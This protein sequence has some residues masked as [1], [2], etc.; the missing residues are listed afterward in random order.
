MKVK[1]LMIAI[2][3]IIGLLITT[4]VQAIEN[5]E[6]FDKE[7]GVEHGKFIPHFIGADEYMFFCIQHG[8]SYN[9]SLSRAT[10]GS[11]KAGDSVSSWCTAESQAPSKP[12][13]GTLTTLIY[14]KGSKVEE[15][16]N[17][18]AAYVLAN[19]PNLATLEAQMSIWNTK[20]NS[21][22]KETN[23]L[24]L[25]AVNYR[26]F[27]ESIH[28]NGNDIFDSLVKDNTVTDK[29][30]KNAVKVAVNQ[31]DGYYTVGPFN[32]SYPNSQYGENELN[33]WSMIKNVTLVDQAG[34]EIGDVAAGKL[35]ILDSNGQKIW[36]SN[37]NKDSK[38]GEQKNFP[39]NG[40][41]FYIK[42]KISTD[43]TNVKLRV[44]FEYLES[45][46]A[47]L[48]EFDGHIRNWSWATIDDGTHMHKR[49]ED[50][51]IQGPNG[52]EN[53]P[54]EVDDPKPKKKYKLQVTDTTNATQK[55][56]ALVGN[57]T[58]NYKE[59]NIILAPKGIDITM[60]IS[61]NVFLDKPEGK[62]NVVNNR[63]GPGEGLSGIEVT[64]YDSHGNQVERATLVNNYHQHTGSSTLGT[65]CYTTAVPHEH[66][67]SQTIGGG[68]Y[69]KLKHTHDEKKCFK[70]LKHKHEGDPQKG[71]I[72]YTEPIYHT[73][74][75]DSKDGGICYK[76]VTHHHEGDNTKEGGCYTGVV[77]A[78]TDLCYDTDKKVICGKV[79]G[80][81]YYELTCNKGEGQTFF[82]LDCD[83]EGMVERYD[84]GCGE[85]EDSTE[86]WIL[87][88]K[89]TVLYELDCDKGGKAD[90]YEPNC[91]K[92]TSHIEGNSTKVLQNPTLTKSEGYYEFA[93]LDAQKTYYVRFVYNGMLY[94][95]VIPWG[96]KGEDNNAIDVS[97]ATE[98]AQGHGENRTNFNVKFTEIGSYPSNYKIIN[99]IFGNDLGDYNRTYLQEEIAD[100]FKEVANKVVELDG[101][102]NEA[103]KAVAGSDTER[104]RKVQFIADCRINAYTIKQYP[105]T[106]EFL[107]DDTKTNVAGK[108]YEPIYQAGGKYD[109]THVNLGIKAR[110]TFDMAL[111]KDVFKAVLDINGKSETYTYDE[112]TDTEHKGFMIGID[113]EAYLTKLR[114]KYLDSSNTI[115]AENT[116]AQA[117]MQYVQQLRA[118]EIINGNNG[119][120]KINPNTLYDDAKQY[121][122]RDMNYELEENSRLKIH[123]TYKIAIKNQSGVTG[124]VTEVVDYYDNHYEFES[125]YVGKEDGTPLGGDSSKVIK[126]DAGDSKYKNHNSTNT[127]NNTMYQTNKYKTMYLRPQEQKLGSGEE[128]YIFV[129][130]GLIKPEET[131]TTAGL[132]N[133]ETFAT[134]NLAEIN[135]YTTYGAGLIDRDSTPGNF[136]PQNYERGKTALEDDENQAPALIYSKRVS[137]TLEGNVFED[138]ITSIKGD[139]TVA[140]KEARYGNGNID[141]EDTMIKDIIVE[142]IEVKQVNGT[143]QLIVRQARKT[144]ENGWYGFG[145]FLPGDYVIRFTYG[146]EDQTALTTKT[147]N[148]RKGS[149][150]ISYNGQ[151][152]QSTIFK[153]N[154]AKITSTQEYK[155]D[156]V[157]AKK[158]DNNNEARNKNEEKVENVVNQKITKYEND[159][160]KQYYWYENDTKRSDAYDD[161]AR[162]DQVMDYSK[163]EYE[164]GIINHKAEVFN[165]YLATQPEH[166]TPDA[167]KKLIDE[168]ERRTYRY[169]Y[170]AEMPIEVEHVTKTIVGNQEAKNYTYKIQGVDF[171]VVERPKS[172]LA[173]DQVIDNVKITLTDGTVLIDIKNNIGK[174]Y[175][176]QISAKD[177]NKGMILGNKITGYD[178]QQKWLINM[179]EEIMSGAKLE[180]TYRF[181]LTNNS[182]SDTI[183]G[184]DV[185]N[186]ATSIINY[187]ANNLN[188]EATDNLVNNQPLWEIVKK[189]DIQTSKNSTWINNIGKGDKKLIDLST[190]T[191]IVRAT[192]ANPLLTTKLEPGKS[193]DTTLVVKKVLSAESSSDDLT[194][195]NLTEIAEIANDVGRYDRGAIPGNQGLEQQP[196]EH[197]TSGATKYAKVG[198]KNKPDG[199]II[200]TPPTGSIHIYYVIGMVG[201]VI[202][203]GGIY[204]IKKK[205]LG[206]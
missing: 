118:E 119:N 109:Q 85:T 82:V 125:A 141:K 179:D 78:H 99:K 47:T 108:D 169:A 194:Y 105:L 173:I 164:K 40:K 37:Y 86:D 8:A 6:V 72:C 74:I 87:T 107:I 128:Q 61:G 19:A 43:V 39:K 51:W 13:S 9:A 195:T 52:M 54:V 184:K 25:E 171:G 65:G 29:S 147:A 94:E 177:A 80:T 202:L 71:T 129:T 90:H 24:G 67:G 32:V 28:S 168:L 190:Q 59:T 73:H 193:V 50:H 148:D 166:I 2:I 180:V 183:N 103:Y 138:K 45:C 175:V 69:T 201:A 76:E 68:C 23:E 62:A 42:F 137:R 161:I 154:D 81:T 98:V 122:W 139:T 170:T 172:E 145:A 142:L 20:I 127:P 206:K 12:W 66:I 160:N 150:V 57:A 95:H 167:H 143:K 112:R 7:E 158:Y 46:S 53:H 44:D 84:I 33:R 11:Y 156:D 3:F 77:H 136:N 101:K 181:T 18:D 83:K 64:L 163:S 49:M 197:D 56:V 4:K 1:K 198:E 27:Y 79:E 178:K 104:K 35:E 196:T 123:V 204:L 102:E 92:T 60:K 159:T 38:V 111:Y 153:T 192:N 114:N 31:N 70:E 91:G 121:A 191:T 113:E 15:K 203:A 146:A 200:I 174:N 34:K 75:G 116:Q 22:K 120:D 58:K 186:K 199:N 176:Q 26:L 131:L 36:E 187:V 155:V 5:F 63:F 135:G 133:G 151:D 16:T 30:K 162:R 134:H 96:E 55:L 152:Y 115:Q 185:T 21:G 189:E 157:L 41:D 97:K 132:M 106:K 88:C 149:N 124:S 182:E 10:L 144:D 17:Q 205:V 110:P 14:K 130:L 89:T 126:T 188:F 48:Y 165:S 100:L 93:G 117:N 140:T